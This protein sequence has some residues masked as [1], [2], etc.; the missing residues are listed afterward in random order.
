MDT[1]TFEAFLREL[2]KSE[3]DWPNKIFA[4]VQPNYKLFMVATASGHPYELLTY[5]YDI[6]SECYRTHRYGIDPRIMYLKTGQGQYCPVETL[7]SK[8]SDFTFLGEWE[9]VSKTVSNVTPAASQSRWKEA[10]SHIPGCEQVMKHK[11]PND[12]IHSA[13]N[14]AANLSQALASPSHISKAGE[15]IR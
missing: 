14:R 8:V 7:A 1:K 13:A 10:M 5:Q 6:G 3:K 12:T 15:A 11:S 4:W 2:Q 9:D